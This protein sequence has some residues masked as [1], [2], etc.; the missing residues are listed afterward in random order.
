MKLDSFSR[1]IKGDSL[2]IDKMVPS[3]TYAPARILDL[4][5][6]VIKDKK[7]VHLTW[8]APG[9]ILDQGR[10][11][12]YKIFTSELSSSF[13]KRKITALTPFASNHDAGGNILSKC[14]YPNF[15]DIFLYSRGKSLLESFPTDS[16]P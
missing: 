13:Y 1:I 16:H 7:Q 4:S 10:V 14:L 2:R 11:D 6:F 3:E 15:H 5:A 8:T 12:S 9:E